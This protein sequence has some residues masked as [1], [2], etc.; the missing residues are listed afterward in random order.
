MYQENLFRLIREEQIVLWVGA[1]FSNYAGFPTGTE[2]TQHIYS[3]LSL[4]EKRKIDKHL[5]LSGLSEE[6]VR[7]KGG[8]EEINKL[9]KNLF[10]MEPKTVYY[11]KLIADTPHIKTI[12]T[13]NYDELFE[14]VYGEKANVIVNEEDV[15]LMGNDK[16]SIIKLHGSISQI[17]SIVLTNSDYEEFISR[18]LS[19]PLM[20]TIT[21]LI[22]TK[23]ILF[24]GYGY[25][26]INI[27]RIFNNAKSYLGQNIKNAYLVT[28]KISDHKIT[29]FCKHGIF[30]IKK[31]AETF[32]KD[33]NKNIEDNL[34]DDFN[35]HQ[36]SV[37]TAN[38]IF[39]S[40][41]LG[42]ILQGSND[43]FRIT[44]IQGLSSQIKGE[45]NLDFI[46][47]KEY[48][49]SFKNHLTGESDSFELSPHKLK[50]IDLRV[51]GLRMPIDL[52]TIDSIRLTSKPHKILPISILFPDKDFELNNLRSEIYFKAGKVKSVLKYENSRFQLDLTT[53]TLP[54]AK[55]LLKFE[56]PKVYKSVKSALEIYRLFLYLLS[57]ENFQVHFIENNQ[58]VN[59]A[60]PYNL[61]E[62]LNKE[63]NI[64]LDYF[65]KLK[66]IE[67]HFG[68]RFNNIDNL[69]K[70]TE[71][72]MNKVINAISGTAERIKFEGEITATLTSY[73]EAKDMITQVNTTDTT[74]AFVQNQ[75]EKIIL[76]GLE[77][78]LGYRKIELEHPKIVN[79][80]ELKMGKSKIAR[81][82][83]KDN[84]TI[85]S[86]QSTP[87]MS[88]N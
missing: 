20:A 78:S 40:R 88:N 11:H 8:R 42:L 33:L 12:I 52:A 72:I 68:V 49:N 4:K 62:D 45:I 25:E 5:N 9:L 22:A 13:T 6:Y 50:G 14:K 84:C 76:H 86:Y 64:Y 46:K 57:A 10:S 26:D 69:T 55:V 32:L 53:D 34:W 21:N 3:T 43:Q 66:K 87:V 67:N 18:E 77:L 75:E 59:N 39:N 74:I 38:K 51:E 61:S 80:M 28:P 30:V 63:I 27:W 56:P 54:E 83:V 16:V 65:S 19:T 41:N 1:G 36:V 70:G 81:I 58:V 35:K 7:L 31:K 2:L 15:P 17:E 23:N 24:L 79:E 47:D 37:T 73:N 44:G 71:K 60:F 85:E 48:I 29:H 82:I